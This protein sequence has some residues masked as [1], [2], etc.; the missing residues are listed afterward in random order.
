M[1]HLQFQ[2]V[3]LQFIEV[4]HLVHQPQHTVHAPLH[5][6][7]Q[8][9][10]LSRNLVAVAQLCHRSCYH[11][12]RC[13]ELVRYVGKETH[14]HPVDTLLLLL[15][16]L[17][18]FQSHLLGLYAHPR[19]DE[20]PDD[21]CRYHHIYKICP[22]CGPWRGLY[23]DGN[24][25]LAHHHTLVMIGGFHLEQIFPSGQIGVVCL[26]VV[27][28]INPVLVETL[29]RVVVSD[30]LELR[31]VQCR[32]RDAETILIVP[33]TY[34]R[35]LRQMFLYALSRSGMYQLVV[36]LQRLK[37]QWHILSALYVYRVEECNPVR[38][39]KH[40]CSVRQLAR[41]TVVELIAAYAVGFIIVYHFLCGAVIL[42]Q[43]V[44]RAY[45]E[46]SLFILL[47]SRYVG[48]CC[49]RYRLQFFICR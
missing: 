41:R 42:A 24:G 29:Q 37:H 3:V 34:L 8:A 22:P 36:Y 47:N 15:L 7:Q 45:P 33:Q 48:A 49:A 32:E 5:D 43:S 4:H 38:A 10:V 27:V 21:D 17:G 23:D 14:V 13:A 19:P 35:V 6:V 1:L 16:I 28:G 31:I 40:Q 18:A 30:A 25:I 20:Q 11:G 12:E 44:E 26:T 46:I 9:L 2:R 39:A